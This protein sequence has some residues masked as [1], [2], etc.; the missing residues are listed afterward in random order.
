MDPRLRNFTLWVIAVLLLM[1]SFTVIPNLAKRSTAPD[2]SFSQFLSEVEQGRVLGV[3]IEGPEIRGTSTDG[4]TFQT[5][6]PNEPS[7][8]QRLYGKGISITVR[9][10]SSEVPWFLQLLISWLPFMALI[11][12]WIFLARQTQGA[13]GSW[14]RRA[15][16]PSDEIDDLKRRMDE[17]E[18]R[19]DRPND[20]D[21]A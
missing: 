4:R 14:F 11:V 20:K 3:V 17:I 9:P 10:K 16:W 1:A 12:V 7:W 19:I 18:K 21:K 13:G 5:Y 6:A 15:M 8:M 2:I